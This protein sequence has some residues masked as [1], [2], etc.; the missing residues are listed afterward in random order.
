VD[1]Q[2]DPA[3]CEGEAETPQSEAEEP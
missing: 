2:P 1:I 3:E